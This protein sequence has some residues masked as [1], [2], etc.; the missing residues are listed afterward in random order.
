MP[1]NGSGRVLSFTRAAT[2]VV[3]TVA[4]CHPFGTKAAVEMV[5]P[6]ASALAEDCSVQCS[7]SASLSVLAGAAGLDAGVSA[8]MRKCAHRIISNCSAKRVEKAGRFALAR[9]F[10]E[11]ILLPCVPS[12]AR[13]CS[14]VF[15][16]LD[17]GTMVRELRGITRLL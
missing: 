13:V 16:D 15:A 8:A 3:G 5:S 11:F 12:R 7:R 17:P 6:L 14:I 9:T 4:S 2:T 10:A 1:K